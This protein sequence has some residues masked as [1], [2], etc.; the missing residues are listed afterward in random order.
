MAFQLLDCY[1]RVVSGVKV[2]R[3]NRTR[4]EINVAATRAHIV[5]T[6]RELFLSRGYTRT[7]IAS[8]A[9]TAG[10]AVQTVYN[11]VGNKATLLSEVFESTVRGDHPPLSVPELLQERTR[12]VK[13]AEGLRRLLSGW[14]CEVHARIGP[15]RRVL[16]EASAHDADVARMVTERDQRRLDNY[17]LAAQA[18]ADRGAIPDSVDLDDVAAL[19]WAIGHPQVFSALVEERGWSVERYQGWIERTLA[20]A[21]RR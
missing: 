8:V 3:R 6:A 19:I 1:S 7:T 16:V 2:N 17:G 21:L 9:R 13:D 4:R 15:L 10:V 11:S 18:F 20:A 12:G 5:H 14:F